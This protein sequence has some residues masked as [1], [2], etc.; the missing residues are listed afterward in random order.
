MADFRKDALIKTLRED[1]NITT[2]E[3]LLSAIGSMKKLDI[4]QFVLRPFADERKENYELRNN[5][6]VSARA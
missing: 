2:A 3:Q 4:T 6:S 5:L 1:F